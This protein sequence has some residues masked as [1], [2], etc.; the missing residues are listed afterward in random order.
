MCCTRR[1]R[2]R[3]QADRNETGFFSRNA[4]CSHLS[5]VRSA[6]CL[7]LGAGR[8]FRST[9]LVLQ[10]DLQRRIARARA[11]KF[12]PGCLYLSDLRSQAECRQPVARKERSVFRGYGMRKSRNP[13]HSF[14]ATKSG[15]RDMCLA[16]DTLIFGDFFFQKF[17]EL[18]GRAADRREA[19][20][21]KLFAVLRFAD[22]RH[23][24]VA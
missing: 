3:R 13:F 1:R 6:Q 9:V 7:R 2:C 4:G 18:F 17:T 23:H 20:V 21:F 8:K 14:S 16:H 12:A 11:G 5:V 15:T 24:C 10:Y 19:P 22:D